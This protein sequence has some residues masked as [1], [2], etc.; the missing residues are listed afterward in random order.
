MIHDNCAALKISKINV[1]F[2]K[3]ETF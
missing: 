3:M 1:S 2:S